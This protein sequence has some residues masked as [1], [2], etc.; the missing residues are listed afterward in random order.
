MFAGRELRLDLICRLLLDEG[1]YVAVE[2]PGF[3]QFRHRINQYGATVVP[4]PVDRDGIDV[5]KLEQ[6]GLRF[7]FVLVAPSHHEP[8]GVTMSLERRQQL[9]AWLRPTNT[10]LIED[11]FDCEYRY[12]KHA[13][14]SLQSLDRDGLVIYMRCFWRILFPLMRLGFL[15]LPER[16]VDAVRQAKNKVERDPPLLEQF[17]LTSF[18]NEGHLER[19]IHR[20]QPSYSKRRQALIHALTKY[21]GKSITIHPSTSGL[22]ILTRV[23]LPVTEQEVLSIAARSGISF[24]STSPYYLNSARHLE[25]MVPFGHLSEEMLDSGV[26]AMA[27]ELLNFEPNHYCGPNK[28]DISTE[29]RSAKPFTA[30]ASGASQPGKSISA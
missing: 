14:P 22:E 20:T 17:A 18:I 12:F 21:F 26:S 23:N 8:L 1:D 29:D 10:F 28:A 19:H 16:L 15:V 25:F 6:S 7:K 3:T 5:S 24:I 11:D 30:S 4:I 9:I 13:I 27:K 2:N